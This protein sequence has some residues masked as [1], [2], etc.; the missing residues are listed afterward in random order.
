MTLLAAIPYASGFQIDQFMADLAL[1]LKG[2]GLRLGG[3]V[4]HNDGSCD[5]G[6]LS[7]A[8]EDLASGTRFPISE[9]R[10]AA[11]TGCRLDARGLAAAGGALTAALADGTDLVIVNK[12]GRQEVLGQG[13]RQEIA[14]ALLA[15]VPLLIAVRQDFLPAWREFAGDDWISLAAQ[16]EIIEAWALSLACVTA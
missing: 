13:L 14:A 10:G 9:N 8:L 4:Q 7:M 11:S 5:Q 2:R 6:C 12:F 1:R 16:P 15:D 3:V